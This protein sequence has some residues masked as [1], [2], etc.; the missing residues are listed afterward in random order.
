MENF[1]GRSQAM[2]RRAGIDLWK[3]GAG[4]LRPR[5]VSR[6]GIK[7]TID[8]AKLPAASAMNEPG[9]FGV[10]VMERSLQ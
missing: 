8:A 1:I 9:E 3:P 10:A 5:S 7:M 6:N 2:A 4:P